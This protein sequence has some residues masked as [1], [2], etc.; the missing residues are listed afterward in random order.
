MAIADGNNGQWLAPAQAAK[1]RPTIDA[2]HRRTIDPSKA[3]T[4]KRQH[5]LV[6]DLRAGRRW[7]IRSRWSDKEG[8]WQ[9]GGIQPHWWTY[10]AVNWTLGLLM[11]GKRA[12]WVQIS[13]ADDDLAVSEPSPPANQ[14]AAVITNRI[15]EEALADHKLTKKEE[16]GIE[17]MLVL[18]DGPGAR[19]EYAFIKKVLGR[20]KAHDV[21][22]SPST[23]KR[24]VHDEYYTGG[25]D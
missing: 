2:L 5:E 3:E 21:K 10:D 7:R 8:P 23:G 19:T 15:R 12:L 25:Q 16:F 6:D 4:E 9:A 17:A 13:D 18:D 1:P 11:R 14:T 22:M 24:W 20:L